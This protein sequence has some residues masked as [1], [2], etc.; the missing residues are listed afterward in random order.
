MTKIHIL[1]PTFM[2]SQSLSTLIEKI[3]IAKNNSTYSN[4]DLLLW[5]VDDSAGYDIKLKQINNLNL[6]I[7]NFNL[8]HAR[9]IV[10]GLRKIINDVSEDDII[11]TLDSDGEDGPEDITKLLDEVFINKK[12]ICA[13]KR[14]KRSEGLVFRLSYVFFRLFFRF[15]TG[16][17]IC[18]GN[19]IAWRGSYLKKIIYHP[20]FDLCYSSTAVVLS[21]N[22]SYVPCNRGSRYYG[23]SKMN[24]TSLIMH[25]LRMLMPFLDV[26]T[27]RALIFFG[28][29][30]LLSLFIGAIILYFKFFTIFAIPGWSSQLFAV[31][32][33]LSIISAGNFFILFTLYS[34]SSGAGLRNIEKD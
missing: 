32:I 2:D 27:V 16:R 8:G 22:I 13:A 30:F 24:F 25:G 10:F 14:I 31:M 21:K 15:L 17:V 7:P 33:V 23:K 29:F 12:E 26:I 11:V 20:Y 28:V 34:Q 3:R 18:S 6:L 4:L 5:A 1:C 9:A 19:F